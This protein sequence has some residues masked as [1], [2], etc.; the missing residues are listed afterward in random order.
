MLYKDNLTISLKNTWKSLLS[1]GQGDG[2]SEQQA[3]IDEAYD[4][5]IKRLGTALENLRKEYNVEYAL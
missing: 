5:Y 2:S 1:C 4:N 3:K